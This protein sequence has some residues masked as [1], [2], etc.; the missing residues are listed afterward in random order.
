VKPLRVVLF[1]AVVGIVCSGLLVGVTLFTA[2]YRSANERAEEVRNIL[3]ALGVEGALDE[4]T[5]RLLEIFDGDVEVSEEGGLIFYEYSPGGTGRPQAVAVPFSGVGLWGPV[6]GVL[7]LQPD[8]KTIRAVRFFQQEETPGLGGEIGSRWFQE[9]FEGKQIIDSSGA[10]GFRIVKPGLPDGESAVEGISGATM[11]SD[12][13]AAMLDRL[14]KAIAEE[15][16]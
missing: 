2:P 12:R 9:Q 4:D 3:D 11:T 1:A 5:G 13:V 15:T 14:S 16:R 6:R 7:S 10:A 8:L